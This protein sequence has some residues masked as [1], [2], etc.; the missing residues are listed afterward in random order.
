MEILY[1]DKRVIVCVKPAGILSTD[2]EGGL[3]SL[4]RKELGDERAC[5]RTVH[6]LDQVVGGLM[7]LARSVKAASL[8]SAQVE[9]RTFEKEYLAVVRGTPAQKQGDMTDLLGRD[10]KLRRT[11]VADAPG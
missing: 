4:I 10:K 3:P 8:L 11:Y 7:V 6:R 9:N 5:V 2:E 1:L